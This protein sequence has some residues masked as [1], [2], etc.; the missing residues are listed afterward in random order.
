MVRLA[1]G[2]TSPAPLHH[3]LDRRG[4]AGAPGRAGDP[5][6]QGHRVAGR[7]HVRRQQPGLVQSGQPAS[8][9]HQDQAARLGREQR[10]YLICAAGVVEHHQHPP[11]RQPAAEQRGL[12]IDLPLWCRCG[13][14]R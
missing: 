2:A 9:G 8:A 14:R 7:Q 1:T 11:A 12:V 10:A 4:V 3:L 13:R 5:D 6:E